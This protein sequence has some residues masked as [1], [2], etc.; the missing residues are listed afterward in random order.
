MKIAMKSKSGRKSK[1]ADDEPGD[2][3]PPSPTT[4]ALFFLLLMF[5]KIA[6]DI[7]NGTS[8]SSSSDHD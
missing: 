6:S 4:C 1:M 5:V 8:G 3:S 2:I 7:D